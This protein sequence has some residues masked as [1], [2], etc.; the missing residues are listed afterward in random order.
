MEALRLPPPYVQQI[1]QT[2]HCDFDIGNQLTEEGDNYH[3]YSSH[4]RLSELLS[5]AILSIYPKIAN[6]SKI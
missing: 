2:A 4:K 3:I 1:R 6:V 5:R